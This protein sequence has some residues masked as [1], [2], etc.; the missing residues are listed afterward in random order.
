M[1][2]IINLCIILEHLLFI[3]VIMLTSLTLQLDHPN[4]I[5]RHPDSLMSFLSKAHQGIRKSV[6][7]RSGYQSIRYVLSPDPPITFL[8]VHRSLLT[9]HLLTTD[10]RLHF[11]SLPSPQTPGDSEKDRKQPGFTPHRL[12]FTVHRLPFHLLQVLPHVAQLPS[13]LDP[14]PA[15]GLDT[16]P[17]T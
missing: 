14:M 4:G 9:V 7:R 17:P 2:E 8:T 11:S 6:G 5:P 10:N 15:P 1:K 12:P 3:K 16:F 13:Q